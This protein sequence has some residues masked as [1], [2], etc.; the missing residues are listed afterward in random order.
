MNV[1]FISIFIS[2]I[3][4]R[5]QVAEQ[6]EDRA[7]GDKTWGGEIQRGLWSGTEGGWMAEVEQG[8]KMDKC[9]WMT[10]QQVML[11]TAE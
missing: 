1:S 4:E 7:G 10:E 8:M 5:E 2:F 9:R 3:S 11:I 6:G